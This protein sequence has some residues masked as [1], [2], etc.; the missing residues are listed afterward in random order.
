MS[1][2]ESGFE[3]GDLFDGGAAK[4]RRGPLDFVRPF[5][6]P[7]ASMVGAVS[8]DPL[9]LLLAE[10]IHDAFGDLASERG[11]TRSEIAA[12]CAPVASGEAFDARFRVFAGLGML[13]RARGKAYEGRYVFNPTS[14]AALLV[15][16][17]LAEAGGVEEIMTLLDRTQVGLAQGLLSEDQLAGRLRRVRRDLSITT[18]HLLRLVRSKPIEELVGERHQHQSKAVLLDHARQLVKA[19]SSSFPRL[20]ASGTRLIDEALRYSAAVDEFSD[21]LLQQV[22]ARRD[23][24]M[25][26]PEQYLSAAL[27]APVAAL[28]QVFAATVFDPAGVE[29][30]VAQVLVAAGERRPPAPRRRPPRPAPLPPRPDPVEAAREKALLLHRRRSAALE[31]LARGRQEAD[32]TG[33]LGALPWRAAIATVVDLLQA[34]ADP[35]VPFFVETGE[36]IHVDPVGAVTYASALTLYRLPQDVSGAGVGGGSSAVQEGPA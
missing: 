26:M 10:A 7:V 1:G 27:S 33:T 34:S 9:S 16:E 32:L 36:E 18:A 28:G 29:I 6:A 30:T 21:R 19:V 13:E 2:Q 25:L 17:R 20:R 4:V 14:G 11:L 35:A 12:A 24:S 15:F 22:R 5:V 31:S 8:D 23:F 3:Q